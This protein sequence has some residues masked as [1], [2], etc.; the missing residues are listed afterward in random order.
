MDIIIFII[1]YT[2]KSQ[3]MKCLLSST[4]KKAYIL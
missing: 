1:F 4:T 2:V 3:L